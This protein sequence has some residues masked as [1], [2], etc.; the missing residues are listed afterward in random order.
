MCN[1]IYYVMLLHKLDDT[2]SRNISMYNN[3]IR[4]IFFCLLIYKLSNTHSIGQYLI[5]IQY[6]INTLFSIFSPHDIVIIMRIQI[7]QVQNRLSTIQ[8]HC[9][10]NGKLLLWELNVIFIENK[11]V[12]LF[13]HIKF[14]VNLSLY[15]YLKSH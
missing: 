9:K 13:L 5:F 4:R 3:V 7:N 11:V 2:I 10:W 14:V 15:S 6:F 12:L 8:L 1:F